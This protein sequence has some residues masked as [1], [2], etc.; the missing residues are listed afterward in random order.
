M[1]N[2]RRQA[3]VLLA[4]VL[5]VPAIAAGQQNRT[6]PEF[7]GV[8]APPEGGGDV[9]PGFTVV[10][11]LP[12]NDSG[13]TCDGTNSLSSYS[14]ACTLPFSYAGEDEIYQLN[15][16]AGNNVGFS[17]DLTGSAGDLAL[18]LIGTCD[19]GPSCVANSQDAIGP[20]VGPE[21]IAAASYPVGDYYLYVDSYYNAGS[22]GSCGTYNLTISGVLPVELLEFSVN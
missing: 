2:F 19:S 3:L 14:G 21:V 22:P 5:V 4:I 18:F 9:C 10:G 17:A 15:L 1:R 8:P 7:E 20:G 6:D 12:F 13:N 16:G 11:P